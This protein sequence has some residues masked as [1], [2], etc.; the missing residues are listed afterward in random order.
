MKTPRSASRLLSAPLGLGWSGRSAS[1]TEPSATGTAEAGQRVAGAQRLL[2]LVLLGVVV[3]G[4]VHYPVGVPL[5]ATALGG[6]GLLLW[7]FPDAWLIVIPAVL[8]VVDLSPWTGWLFFDELDLFLLV[9]LAVALW[10]RPLSRA[11]WPFRGTTSLVV[12]ALAVSFATS[13]ILGLLP[14]QSVDFNALYSYY[15][16]YN[17]LR[18][19]KGF[20]WALALLPFLGR[21][22]PRAQSAAGLAA[23]GFAVAL[24]GVSLG[25]VYERYLFPGLFNFSSAYR[26]AATFA[27]MHVG[28]SYL[29]AFLAAALPCAAIPL[30]RL[31]TGLG[32]LATLGLAVAG[33]HTLLV[34]FSRGAYAGGLAALLTLGLGLTVARW[35]SGGRPGLGGIVAAGVCGGF[36]VA[37]FVFFL[38]H[39]SFAWSRLVESPRDLEMRYSH[40]QRVFSIRD[41]TIR[42][43]LFGAGIGSFPRRYQQEVRDAPVPGTFRFMEEHGN[44]H[45]RLVGGSE[46]FYRQRIGTI[47]HESYVVS[48]DYRIWEGVSLLD[49]RICEQTLHYSARCR[50]P[51]F[52]LTAPTGEWGHVVTTLD[53][54]DVG[55]AIDASGRF[56]ADVG[57]DLGR[58]SGLLTRPVALSVLVPRGT[59]DLDNVKVVDRN[60]HNLVTN[61]DFSRGG[62]RWLFDVPDHLPWH[63]KNIWLLWFFEQ[64]WIGMLLWSTVVFSSLVGT[65]RGVWGGR[66]ESAVLLGAMAGFLCVG[67]FGSLLDSPRMLLS[68]LLLVFTTL[69]AAGE[70]SLGQR[71]D[72]VGPRVELLVDLGALPAV[73][74][75]ALDLD[76]HRSRPPLPDAPV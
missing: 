66:P 2:S 28:D 33:L 58:S 53:L 12:A 26:I 5:L 29:D 61:G 18:V 64:G 67:V 10:R 68:F 50:W 74:A 36:I 22:R 44:T 16:H 8:A 21:R 19:G 46:L 38:S 34:T 56:R 52:E 11:A 9:T 75:S 6:Y 31:R 72:R 40:W 65:W 51:N 69:A 27:S 57:P 39:S 41:R 24:A 43:S 70:P 1:G 35:R 20:L 55:S 3:T 54:G 4:L 45:L 23:A 14:L 60:G 7:R 13:T 30:L 71:D 76:E 15:S 73:G 37:A 63:P 48:M 47:P 59:I 32:A 49:V 62:T 25:A 17:S 42:G